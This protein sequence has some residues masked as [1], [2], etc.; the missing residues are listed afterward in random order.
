MRRILLGG[1][2]LKVH[3]GKKGRLVWDR[4]YWQLT[5]REGCGNLATY[6]FLEGIKVKKRKEAPGPDIGVLA[7]SRF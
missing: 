3:K 7:M 6:K 1:E 2:G 5:R 4:L